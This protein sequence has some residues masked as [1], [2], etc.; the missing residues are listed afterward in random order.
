MDAAGPIGPS[1][2]KWPSCAHVQA[3]FAKAPSALLV[4]AKACTHCLVL[5]L[6]VSIHM[7]ERCCSC[8]SCVIMQHLS[9]S[10]P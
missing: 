7:R 2:K 1:K 8:L 10:G 6:P 3:H 9:N 4:K 5:P